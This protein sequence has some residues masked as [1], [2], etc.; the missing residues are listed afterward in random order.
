MVESKEA[1]QEDLANLK[2]VLDEAASEVKVRGNDGRH[3]T[4]D[5]GHGGKTLQHF[6]EEKQA[7]LAE[8][9]PCEVAAL[10]F[11]TTSSFQR[12]N[13]P[14][15]RR[16]MPHPLKAT[17]FFVYEG[18]KKL[19]AVHLQA[20]YKFETRYLWRGLRD[21]V[22]PP[23]FLR[24]GGTEVAC[25]STSMDLDV[26]AS[27]ALSRTPLL[28]RIKVDSPMDLGAEIGWLS[29]FPTEREVLY[30]PLTFLKPMFTQH[31][32]D[33]PDGKVITVKP[34]FPT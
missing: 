15:R 18:L 16:A 8:L 30:P 19:R 13:E 5:K 1:T 4:R 34:S 14:L 3:V 23:S 33:V 22:V 17:T 28:F 31:I 10:R 11:Y 21:R 29:V 25:M 12:I 32:K 27:Y 2:Y 6:C 26:V 7:R 20:S 24:S 9:K